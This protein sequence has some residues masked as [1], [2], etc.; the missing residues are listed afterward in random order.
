MTPELQDQV[1]KLGIDQDGDGKITGK[2]MEKL[3]E[4]YLDTKKDNKFLRYLVTVFVIFS[5]LM[6][7]CVFGAS[8][9]AARLS[10]DT[11]VDPVNGIMYAKGSET[12]IHTEA[13][14]IRNN[15]VIV[16]DMNTKELD[17]LNEI[18]LDNGSMKF[19]VKGYAKSVEKNQVALL[20]EGGSLIYGQEGLVAAT[21]MA[22]TMF[23]LVY[24]D[25]IVSDENEEDV[26]RTRRLFKE[27]DTST[28]SRSA[29]KSP[30]PTKAPAPPTMAP[31][32]VTPPTPTVAPPTVA[33]TMAPT[34][35]LPSC[36]TTLNC[37]RKGLGKCYYKNLQME[38]SRFL[39]QGETCPDSTSCTCTKE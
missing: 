37:I 2:E 26:R 14:A 33:P 25:D 20:V 31:P 24:P 9:A 11:A 29:D 18:S 27:K 12:P 21:G 38:I 13:V 6:T 30:A 36:K 3:I 35:A 8:I 4:N 19:Q 23:N 10:K 7:G 5:F 22:E 34:V 17:V 1:E 28:K 16:N 32:T 39:T 15:G